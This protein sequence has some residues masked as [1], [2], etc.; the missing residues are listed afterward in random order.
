ML[1]FYKDG[2]PVSIKPICSNGN[3]GQMVIYGQKVDWGPRATSTSAPLSQYQ[4]PSVFKITEIGKG[5]HGYGPY[6]CLQDPTGKCINVDPK[7]GGWYLYDAQEW[8]IWQN[9]HLNEKLARKQNKIELLESH[10]SL[11]KDILI[12][13]GIHIVT[14]EQAEKLN[15]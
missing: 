15:L 9:L 8:L 5:S 12:K 3:L 13:Q 10:L 14:K 4:S 6:Y 2:K 11:L 1:E 7:Q